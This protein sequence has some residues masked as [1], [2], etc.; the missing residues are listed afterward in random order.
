MR[1]A[2]D[3]P[4][5]LVESAQKDNT[6]DMRSRFTGGLLHVPHRPAT[7]SLAVVAL[8][9]FVLF[10]VL[11]GCGA[12]AP[13]T[14][15]FVS[16]IGADAGA[17][18][19]APQSSSAQLPAGLRMRALRSMQQ[20]PGYD[21]AKNDRVFSARIGA[22]GNDARATIKAGRVTIVPEDSSFELGI[23]TARIGRRGAL[24][25][26]PT[27]EWSRAEG[28]ELVLERA[29]MQERYLAGPMGLEQSYQIET[30]PQG[31]GELEIEVRFDGL[32][33]ELDAG[34][35]SVVRLVDQQGQTRAAYHDLAVVDA[36]GRDLAARMEVNEGAI[37]LVVE[38]SSAAYPITVDPL[39]ATQQ[40]KL[41]ANDAA[42]GDW[43]GVSVSLSGD[44][45]IVGAYQTATGRGAAYVFVRSGSSW[46]EQAKLTAGEAA[47][48]D[49]F[50]GSVSLSGDTAIVGAPG[51]SHS[52]SG[53]AYVFV[54]SGSSWSQQAK[55]TAGDA[56]VDAFGFS[57]SLS[58]D[59]AIVGA[60]GAPGAFPGA[61]YVFV[62]SG[63]S[64]SEQA[65]FTESDAAMDA[66]FGYSV[67]IS[68]DTAV[69]CAAGEA[70]T[71]GAA[72]VFVRS[73]VSWSKQAKLT[74]SDAAE[75]AGLGSSVSLS[76]ETA[77]VGAAYQGSTGAAYVFERS[78][79]S[80]SQQAKLTASDATAN[81][82]FGFSVSLS[83]ETA[84]VGAREKDSAKGVAY[85]F[86]RSGSS[87]SA[88]AKLTAS[89]AAEGDGFGHSLSLLGETAIVGAPGKATFG[90][91]AYAFTLLKGPGDSCSAARECDS[92][93]C[94]DGVC[95]DA[96]CDAGPCDACSVAS[97]A[98]VDG[99]CA[100]LTGPS[101]DDSNGCTQA[102][103]CQSG[104]CIGGNPITCT[105]SDE[106]HEAGNC[107]SSTG[108]C[109]NPEKSDGSPCT[110]GTCQAGACVSDDAGSAGAGG[111]GGT[112]GGGMAGADAQADGTGCGCRTAP[113]HHSTAWLIAAGALALAASR[114][115]RHA[116]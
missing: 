49:H 35:A 23:H 37:R 39:V 24:R 7:V 82:Q 47:A 26:V 107:D 11:G 27:L 42:A 69:V 87:W 56:D 74:A 9:S 38:D 44:T 12:E 31:E 32:E 17:P 22:D 79:S 45:A 114:R 80:W 65:K 71:K 16:A 90:G 97:G 6:M 75:G 73:G 4:T 102:D 60:V 84:I 20:A 62:R 104:V 21:F 63:T 91:A 10:I 34:E 100:L 103:T 109:S 3:L 98:S 101:C 105:A 51:S 95:C 15:D 59:T 66:F 43:F 116:A 2:F 67:S 29:G 115:R 72:Y 19:P 50:G 36:Q 25:E 61:A 46:S 1:R 78:G 13:E 57:V 48:H 113:S 106:C 54:R 89:D 28:Q 5:G 40:A 112:D 85:V 93:F 94:V 77:V 83:G 86:A 108:T 8:A 68:G 33:P 70:N 41:T 58:G 30:R 76:G 64:W 55:F 52:Y 53:A 111:F 88:Q 18:T 92:G 81:D 96:V 110:G 99:T 14:D